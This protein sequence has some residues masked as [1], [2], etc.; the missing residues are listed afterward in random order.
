MLRDVGEGRAAVVPQG[1]DG[2]FAWLVGELE[3]L[4]KARLDWRELLVGGIDAC[5]E[6]LRQQAM[7]PI[8]GKDRGGGLSWRRAGG[9]SA[10]GLGGSA[11]HPAA[12][13]R[14]GRLPLL[15]AVLLVA[16]IDGWA[17]LRSPL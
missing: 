14:R 1:Q 5:K 13:G 12:A 4:L 16:L 7:G 10:V 9:G 11:Q 6:A 15:L 17:V 2:D 8:G 3:E